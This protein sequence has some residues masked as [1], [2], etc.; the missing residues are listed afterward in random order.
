MSKRKEAKKVW[1]FRKSMRKVP[2]AELRQMKSA[3]EQELLLARKKPKMIALERRIEAIEDIQAARGLFGLPVK[4][5]LKMSG[6]R[7]VKAARAS[8]RA[9]QK[10]AA[11]AAALADKQAKK[12]AAAARKAAAKAARKARGTGS[13]EETL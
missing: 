10:D 5:A 4:K 1:K 7:K 12:A 6:R 9:E 3:L 8:L 2:D 11:K 13:E